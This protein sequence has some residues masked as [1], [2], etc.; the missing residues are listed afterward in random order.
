ML[1][2]ALDAT[3][4]IADSDYRERVLPAL[5]PRLTGVL[6]ERALADAQRIGY[7]ACIVEALAA[8]ALNLEDEDR[9]R[10]VARALAAALTIPV[11]AVYDDGIRAAAL[12]TLAPQ[13][14]GKF[15][16]GLCMPLDSYAM[17]MIGEKFWPLSRHS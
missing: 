7:E 1:E 8:L 9:E 10:S 15:V 4:A 11:M 2:R 5:A 16:L 6:L 13:L 17:S 3:L 12:T 14:T